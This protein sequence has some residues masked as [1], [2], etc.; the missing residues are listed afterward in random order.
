MYYKRYVPGTRFIIP[1]IIYTYLVQDVGTWLASGRL[2]LC[3]V[4]EISKSTS[5]LSASKWRARYWLCCTRI[6]SMY[7]CKW[8]QC[9]LSWWYYIPILRSITTRLDNYQ[10][11]S[12]DTSKWRTYTRGIKVHLVVRSKRSQTRWCTGTR[13]YLVYVSNCT[14]CVCL[15]LALEGCTCT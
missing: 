15:V 5:V 14:I 13:C 3:S 6:Y 7:C 2:T 12:I 8:M 10:V 11:Q 1:G 9:D 4:D